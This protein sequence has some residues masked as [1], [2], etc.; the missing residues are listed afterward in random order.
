M[1]VDLISPQIS[2]DMTSSLVAFFFSSPSLLSASLWLIWN[3]INY[4]SFPFGRPSVFFSINSTPFGCSPALR[5]TSPPPFP[6]F[7]PRFLH[8]FF[9]LF[10]FLPFCRSAHKILDGKVERA[11][12]RLC[13]CRLGFLG[14]SPED[15]EN[16]SIY[17][18][19]I[20]EPVPPI[21]PLHVFAYGKMRRQ[22]WGRGRMINAVW[23]VTK[24]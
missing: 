13:R 15:T 7:R 17:S 2:A 21:F 11:H 16:A 6:V 12:R 10:S 18:E 14:F 4:L 5:C 9:F 20:Q 3:E 22:R 19:T 8:P 23:Q 24:G 1:G